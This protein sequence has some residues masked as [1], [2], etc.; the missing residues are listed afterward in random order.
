WKVNTDD[1][2]KAEQ[3][4]DASKAGQYRLSYTVTDSKKHTIEGGYIFTIVG[5]GYDGK[6]FRFNELELVP[7]KKEYA[8]T[9]KLSLQLNTNQAD[10]T[11]LLFVRPANSVY[12]EPKVLRLKGKSTIETI[13]IVKKDMPN[14]FIEALTVSNG[15]VHTQTKEV[16]V[17]PE[18]R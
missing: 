12:L 16:V 6:E 5:P 17:P 9:D 10:S 3:K 15:R 2:G 18:K 14:F 13:D 4:M 11:V 7:D 1:E 8:P